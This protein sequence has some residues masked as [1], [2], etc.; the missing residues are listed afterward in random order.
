MRRSPPTQPC[1]RLIPK[2]PTAGIIWPCLNGAPGGRPKRSPRWTKRSDNVFHLGLVQA[3]FPGARIVR[4][5][6]APLDNVLSA[7]FLHV[8][9]RDEMEALL[10]FCGLEWDEDVLD[11]SGGGGVVKTA[12][13]WQGR[14]PI[15][16]GSAGRW[17]HYAHRLG[18]LPAKLEEMP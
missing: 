5:V 3:L 2:I 18:H 13:V 11:S 6:R 17:R 7:F 4:T 12:S 15:H 14:E 10:A 8:D 9:P 16:L 1:S